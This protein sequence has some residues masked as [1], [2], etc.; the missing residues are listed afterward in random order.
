MLRILHFASFVFI[1]SILLTRIPL[2][3][4]SGRKHLGLFLFSLTIRKSIK[5]FYFYL[6]VLNFYF[7]LFDMLDVLVF[8][9]HFR[10]KDIDDR[11]DDQ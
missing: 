2:P 4:F 7:G 5:R 8:F 9:E 3:D 10:D 1:R 11:D 6:D